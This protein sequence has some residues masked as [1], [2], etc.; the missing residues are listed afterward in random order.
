MN[1]NDRLE[2][3]GSEFS[4]ENKMW[5]TAQMLVDI[6]VKS[7]MQI[8]DVDEETARNWVVRAAEALQ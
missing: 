4:M 1:H 7:H 8:Y 6:A 3:D 5:E 2:T